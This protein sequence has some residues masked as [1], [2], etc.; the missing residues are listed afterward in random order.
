MESFPVRS[1]HYQ[2]DRESSRS[3]T[4]WEV[5]SDRAVRWY[6]IVP[7]INSWYFRLINCASRECAC[8]LRNVPL[9]EP[10]GEVCW[11]RLR[12]YS[13]NSLPYW[14]GNTQAFAQ[15]VARGEL[16]DPTQCSFA[17][18]CIPTCSGCEQNRAFARA[19]VLEPCGCVSGTET[20]GGSGGLPKPEN[21]TALVAS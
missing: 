5:D 19:M 18:A 17:E 10:V 6:Q 9:P 11:K 2:F 20:F 15:N 16:L 14:S 7:G 3:R 1:D 13:A 4:S 12:P 21:G 8:V